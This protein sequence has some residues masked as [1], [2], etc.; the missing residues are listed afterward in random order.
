MLET[1]LPFLLKI[2]P[3]IVAFF[4]S[5][6]FSRSQQQPNFNVTI[7]NSAP[8]NQVVKT[9]KH[10]EVFF[11]STAAILLY[12]LNYYNNLKEAVSLLQDIDLWCNWKVN[13]FNQ[14]INLKSE[15]IY[16]E[17]LNEVDFKYGEQ[18]LSRFFNDIKKELESLKEIKNKLILAQKFKI[19]YLFLTIQEIDNKIDR[20]RK[21]IKI[22]NLFK[23]S[24]Y[25]VIIHN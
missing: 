18:D 24:D 23:V 25:S 7:N 1:I 4:L 3:A 11:V 13:Y 14:D 16:Q 19:D 12:L 21:I 8:I 9:G 15:I 17:I 6:L 20:L 22:T 5:L 10:Q 2:C